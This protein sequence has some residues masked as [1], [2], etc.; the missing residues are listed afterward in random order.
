M[1]CV[2]LLPGGDTYVGSAVGSVPE[3]YIF[4]RV[5]SAIISYVN[6][7]EQVCVRS[8]SMLAFVQHTPVVILHRTKR[9]DRSLFGVHC[10]LLLLF[11]M[12]LLGEKVE[13][14]GPAIAE[15]SL[16]WMGKKG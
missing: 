9:F 3:G 12:L 8:V 5:A 16:G 10:Y 6:E 2:L 1:M 11:G 15:N 4:P 13:R 14:K 7:R